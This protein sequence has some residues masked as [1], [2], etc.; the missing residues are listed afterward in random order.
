MDKLTFLSFSSLH[1]TRN[2]PEIQNNANFPTDMSY[3]VKHVNFHL[4]GT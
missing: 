3:V 2:I 4:S 1:S